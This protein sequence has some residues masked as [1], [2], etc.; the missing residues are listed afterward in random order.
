MAGTPVHVLWERLQP[1]PGTAGG[2]GGDSHSP[3]PSRLCLLSDHHIPPYRGQPVSLAYFMPCRTPSNPLY[4][5]TNHKP[6]VVVCRLFW[7]KV[8][9]IEV[10]LPTQSGQRHRAKLCIRHP[11]VIPCDRD[12]FPTGL[13][14]RLQLV[15]N[16][17]PSS[18]FL[19]Y[20]S[21]W[22]PRYN[23]AK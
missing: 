2:S 8:G 16:V 7:W 18:T 20:F 11:L 17:L 1:L 10:G 6:R 3:E 23:T 15:T 12:F 13:S 9:E 22:V 21:S 14:P 5:P 19:R 4:P